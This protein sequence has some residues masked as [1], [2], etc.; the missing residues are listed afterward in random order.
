[1]KGVH[2]LFTGYQ[3]SEDGTVALDSAGRPILTVHRFMKPGATWH[4]ESGCV[5]VREKELPNGPMKQIAAFPT[6]RVIVAEIVDFAPPPRLPD[7][8]PEPAAPADSP[9]AS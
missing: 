2:I 8:E 9:E 6:Q 4:L 7:T 1:M 3:A 5:V